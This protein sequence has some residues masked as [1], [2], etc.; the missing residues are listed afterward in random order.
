MRLQSDICIIEMN[1]VLV[2]YRCS[3]KTTVGK[4]LAQD[5]GMDFIDT[6]QV[7]E[8]KT[9]LSISNYVSQNGWESFRRM[10]K[11][12]IKK[13]ALKD[14]LI[15]ATGGGVVIDR[16][17]VKNLKQKG[18]LVWLKADASV[19][20]ERMRKE[21]KSGKSRPALS[22]ANPLHEIEKV[23]VERTKFYERAS[24]NIVDTNSL[25]PEEVAAAILSNPLIDSA[26]LR[27]S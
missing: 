13:L 4:I 10:E 9:G 1:I 8:K 2:G 22:G 16:D 26:G 19:I 11:K 23:L 7:I 5:L 12:I 18:C 17:N 27:Y 24:D 14:N 25:V 6:D 15:I 20:T 3:G 21:E